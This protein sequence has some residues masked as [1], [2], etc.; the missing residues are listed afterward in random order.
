MTDQL[1]LQIH[2]NTADEGP[3]LMTPYTQSGLVTADMDEFRTAVAALS[4]G[5]LGQ[6]TQVVRTVHDVGSGV[7]PAS[8]NAQK[9]IRY[10]VFFSDDVTAKKGSFT[11]P[12]ADL[13]E[14]PAGSESIDITT[15]NG[16]LMATWV[17]DHGASD[18]GNAVTCTAIRYV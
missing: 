2:D 5:T 15:G 6:S 9:E 7:K 8:T 13:T 14:L 1:A 16:L 17:N 18:V 3:A 11:I 10:K 4:I 12:C